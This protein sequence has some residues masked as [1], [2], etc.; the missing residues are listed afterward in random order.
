MGE[1]GPSISKPQKV[2]AM[3]AGPTTSQLCEAGQVTRPL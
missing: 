2:R 1:F 3:E